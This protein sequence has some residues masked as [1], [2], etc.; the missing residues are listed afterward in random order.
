M[1]AF[2]EACEQN[3]GKSQKNPNISEDTS[4]SESGSQS[5]GSMLAW[6]ILL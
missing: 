1:K 6:L 4:G 5:E 2:S 3:P